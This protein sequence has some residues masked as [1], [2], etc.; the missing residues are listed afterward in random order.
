MNSPEGHLQRYFENS[1]A[2]NLQEN[3]GFALNIPENACQSCFEGSKCILAAMNSIAFI[4]YHSWDLPL[5]LFL[6][7]FYNLLMPAKLTWLIKR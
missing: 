7:T 2:T 3:P 6:H 5:F 1:F 4:D